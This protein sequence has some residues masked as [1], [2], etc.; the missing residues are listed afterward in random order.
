MLLDQQPQDFRHLN[1]GI[2]DLDGFVGCYK[3]TYCFGIV[4]IF[5]LIV[6][7]VGLFYNLH[8]EGRFIRRGR[9]NKEGRTIRIIQYM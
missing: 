8:L 7:P 3:Y 4:T 1:L 6:R 9:S 2:K 5:L